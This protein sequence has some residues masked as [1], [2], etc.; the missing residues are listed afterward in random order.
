MFTD[1]S[2][3]TRHSETIS[4]EAL[5]ERL[6]THNNLLMPVVA[7][8]E[9]RIIKTIGDALMITFES[10]TNA[11]Q[12]GLFMQHTLKGFNNNRRM[13]EQIRIKVAINSGEVTVTEDDVFGDAVNIAAKIEKATNPDETYFT[14]PVFLAMKRAEVPSAFVKQFRPKGEDS[15]EIKLYKVV[16][17]END[18]LYQRIINQTNIDPEQVQSR[19]AELS[20]RATGEVGQYFE[21]LVAALERQHTASRKNI[22]IG[23]AALLLTVTTLV[24]GSLLFK[25]ISQSQQ[26]IRK[27]T[28]AIEELLKYKLEPAAWSA[29]NNKVMSEIK[30]VRSMAG[31]DPEMLWKLGMVMKDV[32]TET[33][34]FPSA[35][36]L[37]IQKAISM[38]I[39][40]TQEKKEQLAHALL[41]WLNNENSSAGM[42]RDMVKDTV[43]TEI[44]YDLEERLGDKDEDVRI[45]SA[46]ILMDMGD[47]MMINDGVSFFQKHFGNFIT[48][49]NMLSRDHWRE[50]FKME[51]NN[52]A[53]REC[54]T[55]IESTMA[56]VQEGKGILSAYRDAPTTLNQML[57]DLK[58]LQP[59]ITA[60][61][62]P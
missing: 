35:G 3:F 30:E 11:V 10:P 32:S 2:G 53:Y 44:K 46:A 45:N 20:R 6:E 39:P 36:V 37:E 62:T 40:L 21:T 5:M 17:D 14:E 49:G 18:E 41:D 57:A 24:C 4:R 52:I 13:H 34:R 55:L 51:M 33:G 15:D 19:S 23:A 58:E 22:T 54:R 59:E 29:N 60:G 43:Y 28:E 25:S 48:D 1:I 61:Y 31:E 26:E 8:F 47:S 56:E 42:V 16:Q 7:H 50:L 27:R 12:C 9:G 38:G